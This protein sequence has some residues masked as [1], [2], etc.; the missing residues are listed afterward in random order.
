MS[1][2]YSIFW[3][4]L[5]CLNIWKIKYTLDDLNSFGISTMTFEGFKMFSAF[6]SSRV[7]GVGF[8]ALKNPPPS[9]PP[10]KGMHR[11]NPQKPT[12]ELC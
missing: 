4:D 6:R 1:S 8:R 3:A 7:D 9:S 10:E 11:L 12:I 5:G 2:A